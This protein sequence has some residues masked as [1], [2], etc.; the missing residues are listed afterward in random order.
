MKFEIGIFEPINGFDWMVGCEL[1]ACQDT[2]T[3]TAYLTG[4]DRVEDAWQF[5]KFY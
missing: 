3:W 4:L 1:H 5:Q 2:W